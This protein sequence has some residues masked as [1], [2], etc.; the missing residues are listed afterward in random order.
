MAIAI[1]S[2]NRGL[3]QATS[4]GF[5]EPIDLPA[6]ASIA[7]GNF[8]ILTAAFDNST[9]GGAG[10][11]MFVASSSAV[12]ATPYFDLRG[13]YWFQLARAV[14]DPGA[15]NEGA[16]VEVWGCRVTR[17]YSNG[18]DIT[19]QWTDSVGA[20]VLR[21]AE[22]SGVDGLSYSVVTPITGTGSST[23]I[24]PTGT[25]TPAAAGQ[26]VVGVA[27]VE[28]NGALTADA[29]ATDGAWVIFSTGVVN[30]GVDATSMQVF[31]QH[32][33]VT[34][35]TAQDWDITKA[36][37]SD[38]A[39]VAIVLDEFVDAPSPF[40][41]GNPNYP[42]IAGAEIL[43]LSVL[44][45]PIDTGT[46]YL[47]TH[48]IFPNDY[49]SQDYRPRTYLQSD[50]ISAGS[51]VQA[52]TIAFDVYRAGDELARD[53]VEFYGGSVTGA[54]LGGGATVSGAMSAADALATPG[55]DHIVLE[56]GSEYVECIFNVADLL[57]AYSNHRIV[58]W[59]FVYLAWKDDSSPPSP[60][61]GLGIE[62]RDN[63]ADNGAGASNLLGY[64]LVQNYQ[65]DAQYETRWMGEANTAIRGKGSIVATEV[66]WGASYTV[67]NL[68]HMDTA[69][70][71]TRIRFYGGIGE[72]LLQTNVYLD[73]AAL[74]VELIPE[75][76]LASGMR[77]AINSPIVSPG[78][79]PVG[80]AVVPVYNALNNDTKWQVPASSQQYVLAVREALPADPSDYFA[81][82]TSGGRSLGGNEAVGAPFTVPSLLIDRPTLAPQPAIRKAALSK[83]RLVS[84]PVEVDTIYPAITAHDQINYLIEGSFWPAYISDSPGNYPQ[85]YTGASKTQY[86]VVDGVTEYDRIKILLQ[87]DEL[88]TVDLEIS[89]EQPLATP[90][91]TATVTVAQALARPD[92]GLGWREISVPLDVAITPAAGQVAIEFS[93]T[94][95]ANAPWYVALGFTLGDSTGYNIANSPD[96]YAVVLECTLEPPDASLDDFVA[97]LFRPADRC[98]AATVTL[99]EITVSNGALYDYISI[100]RT[101]N[102]GITWTGVALIEDPSNTEIYVD[103]S[104]PWDLPAGTI[105]YLVRGYR[106][107]DHL[108]ASTLLAA[109]GSVATAPGAAFGIATSDALY[110]YTPVTDGQTLEVT[111][112]PLNPTSVVALH[113]V[114]HQV[115]LR[116]PE[117]RGLSITVD[118]L[119]DHILACDPTEAYSPEMVTPGAQSFTPRPFEVFR[120][121]E[122]ID[123]VLLLPGGHT[124]NVILDVGSLNVTVQFGT[125]I[126]QLT[127]TDRKAVTVQPWQP[128][129]L[130]P[131]A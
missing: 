55:G 89:I 76:R 52:H 118:V 100:E 98:L 8:L 56:S 63:L 79:Y 34:G 12:T 120:S 51:N 87:P 116:S 11:R 70:Q 108:V 49:G 20:A 42:C 33:I 60:G 102:S 13:N 80:D 27:A 119:V 2:N 5:D 74:V 21:I 122:R 81:V 86:V 66:G 109:W 93:A 15:A 10:P 115:A 45:V 112:N 90:I 67:N 125:Y 64:Y 82:Q 104:A 96:D 84:T 39:A 17:A 58:R 40:L 124:R 9:T 105:I 50:I 28:T 95:E 113:G 88:T 19:V 24:G 1:V 110:A 26:M 54:S 43:P 103:H 59:G 48:Q 126:G 7:V 32:K 30:T 71:T 37:A 106:E 101:I 77:R 57:S 69:D 65:R 53:P 16:I 128:T 121:L 91:A 111:W 61:E 31:G 14:R 73:Y 23:T 127:F 29:D 46:E 114:D 6:G 123:A 72:D 68:G 25:I 47:F 78:T 85:V 36:G 3:V 117:E 129:N 62:W 22:Y 35:T 18:D 44:Q 94:T 107:S 130:A 99:P 41:S 75:R 83:G 97:P 92:L 131:G 38:F 4:A